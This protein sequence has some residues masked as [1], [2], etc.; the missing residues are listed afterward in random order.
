M[1]VV[2]VVEFVS[3]LVRGLLFKSALKKKKGQVDSR[4]QLKCLCI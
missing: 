3:A 4:S 1:V 2:V